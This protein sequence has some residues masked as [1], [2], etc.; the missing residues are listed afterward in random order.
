MA[1]LTTVAK[2]V[3]YLGLTIVPPSVFPRLVSAASAF[4]ESNLNRI[5]EIT[6]Y[7]ETRSGRDEKFITFSDYPVSSV[8]SVSIDGQAIPAAASIT[9]AGYRFDDTRLVLNGYRFNRGLLNVQIAYSAG[10]ATVP[11][12][13][14]QACLDVAARKYKE[15]DRV[16]VNSK[17]I[18][19]ETVVFSKTDMTDEL[20]SILR[21]YQKVVPV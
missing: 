1:D 15:R 12:E 14:E 9:G 13:V 11:Y 10:Y 7:V 4:I 18:N 19:G 2:L 20:K 17:I 3:E 6:D 21:A 16:G 5:F 8:S